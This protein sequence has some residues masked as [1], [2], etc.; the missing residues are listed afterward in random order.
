VLGDQVDPRAY[1]SLS[2]GARRFVSTWNDYLGT[3]ARL[4]GF[5]GNAAS[6]SGPAVKELNAL[7]AS[8]RSHSTAQFETVRRRVVANLIPRVEAIER[9]KTTTEASSNLATRALNKLVKDDTDA[10][11]IIEQV[12]SRYPHGELAEQFK[13]R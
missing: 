6:G 11:I 8:A 13:S 1:R 7:I 12:N 10:R 5:I 2:S 9:T 3:F 4:L